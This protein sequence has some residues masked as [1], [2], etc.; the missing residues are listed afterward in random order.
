LS[1]GGTV[2]TVEAFVDGV[3]EDRRLADAL[4]DD[5]RRNLALAEAGDVDVF[6]NV[7]VCVGDAGL[8]LL[9]GHRNGDL[10]ARGAQ[11]FDR[12]LHVGYLLC[13]IWFRGG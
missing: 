5:G 2:E 4:V 10:G 13:S 1:D 12:G 11:L 9:R 6:G 8:Q 3:L 7:T